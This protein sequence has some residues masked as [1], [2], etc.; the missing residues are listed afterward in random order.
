MKRRRRIWA[1]GCCGIIG[2][3]KSSALKRWSK[4]GIL[5]TILD[6]ALAAINPE[7][8][9]KPPLICFVPEPTKE[10][11][12]KGWLQ[13]YYDNQSE[14]A[15]WFQIQ[16]FQS[17]V[18]AVEAV[19]A[20]APPDRDLIL[21]QERTMYDQRLFWEQQR[22]LGYRTATDR[23]HATYMGI[24]QRWRQFVPEPSFLLLFETSS[25]QTTMQRVLAR[26]RVEEM[27]GSFSETELPQTGT[28][29]QNAAGVT[30]NYQEN[31]LKLHHE[32]YSEPVAHPPSAGPEG[33]P[34]FGVNAD[35]P[36]HVDDAHLAA[37]AYQVVS[38]ILGVCLQK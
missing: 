1:V 12:A 8:E 13:T 5:Q 31:L 37:L 35:K 24:W 10:W 16:V 19:I 2:V 9:D 25:L 22:T 27:G 18:E 21:I 23:H 36:F 32:W 17:H 20:A 29:I 15:F 4:T 7:S 11:R 14:E 6:S 26:A 28:E 34:C 30:L 3:G 33:I 38:H